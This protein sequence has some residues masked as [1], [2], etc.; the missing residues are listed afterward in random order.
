M[1]PDAGGTATMSGCEIAEWMINYRAELK[2][3]YVIWGQRIWNA[4]GSD[5]IGPWTSWRGMNDRHD[6]TQNHW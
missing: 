2:L 3:K 6:V 5:D 1:C 4:N